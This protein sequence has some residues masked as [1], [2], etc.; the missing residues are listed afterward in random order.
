MNTHLTFAFIYGKVLPFPI[1]ARRKVPLKY[2]KVADVHTVCLQH[3]SISGRCTDY[4]VVYFFSIQSLI[5]AQNQYLKDRFGN[6]SVYLVN[7]IEP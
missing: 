4:V 1:E 6:E 7:Q 3:R 2:F 5:F